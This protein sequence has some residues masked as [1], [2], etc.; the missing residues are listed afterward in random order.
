MNSR[1]LTRTSLCPVKDLLSGIGSYQRIGQ[2]IE[3]EMNESKQNYLHPAAGPDA[4]KVAGLFDQT[5][6]FDTRERIS[7]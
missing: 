3:L 5:K 2:P 7:R 4:D 1:K 6:W